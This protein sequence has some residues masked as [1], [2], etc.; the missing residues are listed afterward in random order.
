MPGIVDALTTRELP[1]WRL[2]SCAVRQMALNEFADLTAEEFAATHL[3]ANPALGGTV[4]SSRTTKFTHDNVTVAK[5]VD[6]RKEGAVTEV[7]NQV[8]RCW[9][10]K[11]V[12]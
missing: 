4:R 12:G 5:S 11:A 3:G 10:C 1:S 2:N 6:W 9:T 7:K 8:C